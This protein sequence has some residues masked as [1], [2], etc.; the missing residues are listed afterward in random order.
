MLS[1]AQRPRHTQFG[2]GGLAILLLAVAWGCVSPPP[3]WLSQVEL[4]PYRLEVGD[5]VDVH[6]FN[7]PRLTLSEVMIQPDGTLQLFMVG[8]V[9]ARGN[10]PASLAEML[11]ADYAEAGVVGPDVVVRL[12]RAAG[13]RVFIGGEV[14]D[15]GMIVHEGHLNLVSAIMQAGGV[16]D[17]G[18]LRRV[19][20]LRDPG[21]GSQPLQAVVNVAELIDGERP[22]PPL[23]PYDVI[24]VPK[25]TIAQLNLYVDQYI[26][27]MI[28]G[29][30]SYAVGFS[31]LK[32]RVRG[33]SSG[34]GGF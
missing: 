28:P 15:P 10:T 31:Y 29:N 20:V 6:F 32:G 9:L 24:L 34:G 22:S 11:E 8:S 18:S 5:I 27:K 13:L 3:P 23:Q 30:M 7:H 2:V 33:S 14:G 19:I 25:S 21:D 16:T 17:R 26:V 1:R 12:R 4:L